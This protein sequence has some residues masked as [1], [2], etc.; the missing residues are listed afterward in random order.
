MTIRPR[1][2]RLTR[3]HLRQARDNDPAM[4]FRAAKR[5]AYRALVLRETGRPELARVALL[6]ARVALSRALDLRG[7]V[8]ND[9]A[10]LCAMGP[11]NADD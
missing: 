9:E 6:Q 5:L 1:T 10:D 2:R 4:I 11:R 8:Q 7:P 3:E